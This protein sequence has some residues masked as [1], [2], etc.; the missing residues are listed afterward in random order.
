MTQFSASKISHY[1]SFQ[2]T[3]ESMQVMFVILVSIWPFIQSLSFLG[4]QREKRNLST[5]SCLPLNSWLCTQLQLCMTMTILE[6]P[7]PFLLL[8][9]IPR[10]PLYSQLL[11]LVPTTS[12]WKFFYKQITWKKKDCWEQSGIP[13]E[14]VSKHL[15]VGFHSLTSL[16]L[17]LFLHFKKCPSRRDGYICHK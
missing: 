11:S 2:I 8:Q 9:E 10:F 1:N 7:M 15:I 5:Q 14:V 3:I 16:F 12:W 6:G 17:K 13:E 4:R